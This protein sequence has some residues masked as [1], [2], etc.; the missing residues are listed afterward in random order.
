[1]DGFSVCTC[2]WVLQI[3]QLTKKQTYIHIL[4]KIPD[5][6]IWCVA[7][8]FPHPLNVV[9]SILRKTSASSHFCPVMASLGLIL[10]DVFTEV[11]L[12]RNTK[13]NVYPYML[14]KDLI[15]ASEIQKM[16]KV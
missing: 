13:Q 14:N 10:D 11:C 3:K 15:S 7:F 1:M 2:L 9:S 12:Y 4:N 8:F 6:V 16:E 5:T